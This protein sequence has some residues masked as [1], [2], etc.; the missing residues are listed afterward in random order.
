MSSRPEFDLDADAYRRRI[1]VVTTSAGVV[2]SDL[3]DDFHH[4]VVTLRHHG[5]HVESVE[6][7]SRRWP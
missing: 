4:F 6:A 1:R 5:E 3:Q 7:E 2:Q